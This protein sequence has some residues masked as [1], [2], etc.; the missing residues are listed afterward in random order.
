[1]TGE[2]AGR[3]G[4]VVQIA[5][6]TTDVRKA[7]LR[8]HELTGAGPFFVREHVPMA[9]VTSGGGP[10][11]FD[12]SCALGQ[13]GDVMIE[14][15]HHHALEPQGLEDVMRRD[16]RG[17]H[18]VAHFVDDLEE[19]RA[20]LESRDVPLVMDAQSEEVR[21]LFFDPGPEVGHLIECYEA[22]DYL[23]TLYAKVRRASVGWDGRNVLRERS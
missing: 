8:W 2:A 20:F 10:A 16:G 7:A 5:Y 19:T 21:F 15:V 1:M 17:V 12:H 9:G 18:H 6:A 4:P 22:T 23:R 3:L 13:Y 11:V 14:L